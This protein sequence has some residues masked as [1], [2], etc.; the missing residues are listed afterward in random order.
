MHISDGVLPAPVWLGCYAAAGCLTAVSLR[1]IKP[2]HMP[3]LALITSFFFVASL[4][5]IPLGPTSVHLIL[6]GLLGI[7]AGTMVF[8][9]VL[10][11]LLLQALLFRHGGITTLGA[12]AL[13]MGLPAFASYWLFRQR[14]RVKWG[15]AEFAFGF[16][17]G[18]LAV[19]LAAVLLAGML[20]MCG[21]D[22]TG[23]AVAATVAHL[24]VMAIEG[25]L[26]GLVVAFLR[27]VEPGILEV[28]YA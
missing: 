9:P 25:L 19:F 21:E 10:V 24:P 27:K 5:H 20:T 4:V 1:K 22:F 23:L 7:I 11:G 6:S 3:R 15:G 16:A 17:S 12:N 26:T 18:F 28:N 8:V 14:R 2:E 13:I